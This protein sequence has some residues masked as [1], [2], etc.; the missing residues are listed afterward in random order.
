MSLKDKILS[1]VFWQGLERVGS[2]GIGFVISIILA[3]LLEPAQFGVIAI[4][5]VFISLSSVF[6]DSGFGSALVQKKD[7]TEADCCSVFY[8]NIGMAL[9][10]YAVL[11]FCAPW[12]AEFYEEQSISVYLRV[13]ALVLIIRSFSMVQ[14]AML[15]KKMLFHLSFR[16][17]WV[18]LIISGITGTVMAYCGYGVWAL[19][20]Q[21]LVS[22]LT[23]CALQ[24]YWIKWRPQLLF[25]IE[26]A[27]G[28]FQFGWKLFCSAFLDTLYNDIYSIV[29]GK[30][31]DLTM[32]SYYNRGKTIPN[33]G[34]GIINS[35][36]GSVMFP[37]FA[38][39]QND[40][41]KMRLLAKRG[42][43]N[44]MFA[45][46]PALCL[47]FILADPLVRILFTEKWLPCVIFL[48]LSCVMFF[49]WPFHTMN[50]QIIIA[51]GRS[52]VFL[53]LEII[54]K[55][56]AVLVI[57]LTYRY[58]V[59]TMV[60]AG[61]FM[62][63]ISMIENSWYNRK[64]VGYAPWQQLWDVGALVVVALISTAIVWGTVYLIH[65]SWAKLLI[66]G[67]EFAIVYMSLSLIAKQIPE[68]I[69]M[70]H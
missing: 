30:I 46:I 13:L 21:Q 38:E 3:R 29:I 16:I 66:G 45:V 6:V 26:R 69:I 68:D 39:I 60:A 65:N 23:T 59:V 50:L 67:F 31:A 52:D 41:E 8:I 24:W 56:Q 34:M 9:L 22:A 33:L 44:I 57:L 20:A 25:S 62:G 28:L 37:A 11:F 70:L 42:L 51:C 18:A 12:I 14:G 43:K 1:G 35:T 4:M 40:R 58:G 64:L 54:K 55:I 7:M 32:L 5:T 36:I 49:F 53:I 2:Q 10:L 47:L 15:I 17:S 63:L 61:A 48:K 27:K 19:I